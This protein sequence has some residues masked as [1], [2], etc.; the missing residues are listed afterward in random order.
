LDCGKAVND[1]LAQSKLCKISE[2]G[3]E[4]STQKHENLRLYSGYP[5]HDVCEG[6]N[7]HG[8]RSVQSVSLMYLLWSL[9]KSRRNVRGLQTREERLT[10]ARPEEIDCREQCH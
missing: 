1:A 7:L 10:E 6:I 3:A 8:G 4:F 2:S 9:Q 5:F